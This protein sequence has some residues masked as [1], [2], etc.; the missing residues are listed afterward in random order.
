MMIVPATCRPHD[1][2]RPVEKR[3]VH[4]DETGRAPSVHRILTGTNRID[5]LS[6]T[7]RSLAQANVR[8]GSR[9][10]SP[11]STDAKTT[12]EL[13]NFMMDNDQ[14]NC[15]VDSGDIHRSEI[16]SSY[17]GGTQ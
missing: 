6:S 8:G 2:H 12:D 16:N 13:L 5:R 4:V 3:T 15:L 9:P 7:G 11:V 10:S 17:D 14:S 1:V